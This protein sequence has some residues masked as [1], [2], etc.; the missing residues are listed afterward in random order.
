MWST[1]SR[2]RLPSTAAWMCA[3]FTRVSP[4]GLRYLFPYP[5]TYRSVCMRKSSWAH[6]VATCYRIASSQDH[7]LLLA[8]RHKSTFVAM[9]MSSR[10]LV[11]S[12]DPIYLSVRPCVSARHPKCLNMHP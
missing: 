10:F 7:S 2:S 1:P 4:S 5:A 8:A 9:T 11:F 3:S 12:Q 6:G